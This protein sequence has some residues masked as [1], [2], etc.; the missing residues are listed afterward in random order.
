MLL[1]ARA[2]FSAV[3]EAETS[4]AHLLEHAVNLV[5]S[6]YVVLDKTCHLIESIFAGPVDPRPRGNP[7]LLTLPHDFSG[8]LGLC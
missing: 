2:D 1:G 6:A 7:G 4:H 5:S 8:S 3:S